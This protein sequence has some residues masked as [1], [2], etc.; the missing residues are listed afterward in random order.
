MNN[1]EE[2]N[3]YRYRGPQSYTKETMEIFFGREDELAAIYS[4][5]LLNKIFVLFGVSGLGKSSLIQAGILHEVETKT[6]FKPVIITFGNYA[7]DE[8]AETEPG[9]RPAD[10]YTLVNKTWAEVNRSSDINHTNKLTE[11]QIDE[12]TLFSCFKNLQH[13]Q[14]DNVHHLLIFDQ[15][16]EIF[17]YPDV[18]INNFL[19]NLSE[20]INIGLPNR[21]HDKWEA[22]CKENTSTAE[23]E[24]LLFTNLNIKCL[25]SIR[26]DYL[27]LL[28]RIEKF[29]PLIL[30]NSYELKSLSLR[31]AI[32]AIK[33]PAALLNTAGKNFESP[34]FVI[35]RDAVELILH[36]LLN[37][38]DKKQPVAESENTKLK[39]DEIIESNINGLLERNEAF[40]IESIQLQL[41]CDHIEKEF[42][43]AKKDLEITESD[44]KDDE[45][46]E[47]EAYLQNIYRTYYTNTLKLIPVSGNRRAMKMAMEEL[48][49]E[50]KDKAKR[51]PVHE[52]KLKQIYTTNN[53][54]NFDEDIK[55]LVGKHLI[56]PSDDKTYQLV[57]DTFIKSV[58]EAKVKRGYD[59]GY[60]KR[61]RKNI[62]MLSAI[63]IIAAGLIIFGLYY[64]TWDEGRINKKRETVLREDLGWAKVSDSMRKEL[65]SLYYFNVS[66]IEY[67]NLLLSKKK[68]IAVYK[69]LEK[70]NLPT[71]SIN[72][73]VEIIKAYYKID[74]LETTGEYD[75]ACKYILNLPDS[76]LPNFLFEQFIKN[77]NRNAIINGHI[78]KKNGVTFLV[79]LQTDLF[80]KLLY[81]KN[82]TPVI[83]PYEYEYYNGY[84]NQ[85]YKKSF[86]DDMNN[87]WLDYL[88]KLKMI[89]S[90][91]IVYDKPTYNSE[92]YSTIDTSGKEKSQ[93]TIEASKL[94]KPINPD[95]VKEVKLFA[96]KKDDVEMNKFLKSCKM[97]EKLEIDGEVDAVN[98]NYNKLKR[99]EL[100]PYA[101]ILNLD[102]LVKNFKGNG[103]GLYKINEVDV[104]IKKY[105]LLYDKID[106]ITINSDDFIRQYRDIVK[107]INLHYLTVLGLRVDDMEAD[108]KKFYS[109]LNEVFDK[110]K[111]LEAI[112]MDIADVN[113][114]GN[115]IT[116]PLKKLTVF[117]A[118]TNK[119][120]TEFESLKALEDIFFGV[121]FFSVTK[122]T[123]TAIDEPL[124]LDK[125]IHLKKLRLQNCFI[126]N[127]PSVICRLK[128][129]ESL[130]LSANRIKTLPENL[131]QLAN[132][133]EL[134]LTGN[135]SLESLPTSVCNLKKLERAEL[136]GT[137]I[138]NYPACFKNFPLLVEVSI[139]S[140]K[141]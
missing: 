102:Y 12:N 2:S 122:D 55:L 11:L 88:D 6:F 53:G 128:S 125:L 46:R 104:E 66:D 65:L 74:T 117:A 130:N 108:K 67:N 72:R 35:R 86:T 51:I 13:R 22:Y 75:K 16:E 119:I 70:N 96:S 87:L 8:A 27:Y 132:L 33:K 68:D 97:L 19:N 140:N 41:I 121:S 24:A 82:R 81:T 64:K 99:I 129:L 47:G 109:A 42:V 34:P 137:A 126:N 101:E 40:R 71:D 139:S 84:K 63:G 85:G 77:K 127:I 50:E 60:Q 106:S 91:R 54:N 94:L 43:I 1:T 80:S 110:C 21:Y 39:E 14:P 44:F 131:G 38:A 28:H 49:S 9:S 123:I 93:T 17:S 45:G 7:G 26:S 25:F 138:K 89:E 98:I 23:I 4:Q 15:F 76:F 29:F 62:K 95:A 100:S 59:E 79:T 105:A 112:D 116:L 57:H 32:N 30:S 36:S 107:C 37:K 3:N 103:I 58:Q 61:R 52:A 10:E 48:I 118:N 111:K 135:D 113:L 124:W 69:F 73:L 114:P 20:L 83:V 136:S 31:G 18:T 92:R 78:T 5:L 120:P 90:Q 133:K 115:I 56:R 141:H 134:I